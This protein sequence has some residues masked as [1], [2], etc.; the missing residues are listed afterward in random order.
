MCTYTLDIYGPL[1]REQREA[2]GRAV[3][4]LELSGRD[5]ELLGGIESLTDELA[6]QAHDQYGIDCLGE[7]G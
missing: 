6:D 2:L 1:F 4:G 7:E 5:R 3:D